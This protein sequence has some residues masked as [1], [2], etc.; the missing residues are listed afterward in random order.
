MD[1]LL[2]VAIQHTAEGEVVRGVIRAEDAALG[3]D[4]LQKEARFAHQLRR[5]HHLEL[6]ALDP[7][8][9]GRS[10]VDAQRQKRDIVG[11]HAG[12]GLCRVDGVGAPIAVRARHTVDGG[13]GGGDA[14][15]LAAEGVHD[16]LLGCDALAELFKKLL[17]AALKT[18]I[19]DAEPVLAQRAQ[20]LVRL[21]LDGLGGGVGRD[22]LALGEVIADIVENGQQI[23][24][25]QDERIAVGEKDLFDIARIGA[26]LGEVRKDLLDGVDGELFV[27]VHRAEGALIV[28]APERALHDQAA[29]LAGG[30]INGSGIVHS[31]S[32]KI[33][34][35]LPGTCP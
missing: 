2:A 35:A 28:A 25:R 30:T 11:L 6:A 17:I 15:L 8:V 4:V 19:H 24:H 12:D 14:R 33:S 22:A 32:L 29:C 34:R 13:N 26:G 9:Q 21:A 16:D 20:L 18:D 31:S 1:E 27:L 5:L 3:V 7:V 23:V 10:R